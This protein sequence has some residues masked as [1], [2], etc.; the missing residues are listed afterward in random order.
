MTMLKTEPIGQGSVDEIAAQ[1]RDSLDTQP[2]TKLDEQFAEIVQA[3]ELGD[4]STTQI[5]QSGE[6]HGA[7][8]ITQGVVGLIESQVRDSFGTRD[9]GEANRQL[10]ILIKKT[11]DERRSTLLIEVAS[12]ILP[13]TVSFGV[14]NYTA[15]RFREEHYSEQG[16]RLEL[17]DVYRDVYP[18]VDDLDGT[19]DEEQEEEQPQSYGGRFITSI[20]IAWIGRILNEE[21]RLILELNSPYVGEPL[22][23]E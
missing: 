16:S 4:L 5:P 17:H 12:R 7:A 11:A 22:K 2:R 20:P 15:K 18:D 19:Q 10:E 13:Y 14:P 23:N 8:F 21:G 3:P 1:V 6:K 9:Q